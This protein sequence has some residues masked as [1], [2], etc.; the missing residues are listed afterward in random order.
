MRNWFYYR[1]LRK[2]T[3]RRRMIYLYAM[4]MALQQEI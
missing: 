3:L 4:R 2:R 1:L